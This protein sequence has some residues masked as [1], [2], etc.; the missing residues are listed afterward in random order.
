MSNPQLDNGYIK[1]ANTIMSELA[2]IRIP[3]QARQVLD[4]ILRKTY[5]W[6]KKTDVI[7]LSQF[8]EGTGL[9]KSSICKSLNKLLEMNLI[10]KK[11]SAMSYFTQLGNDYGITYGFQ[12]KFELWSPL[13]KKTTLFK[14]T[15]HVVQKGNRTLPK[16]ETPPIKDTIT[17]DTI[18]KGAY[19]K[20]F[21][22]FAKKYP[23]KKSKAKAFES[24]NKLKKAKM[25]P[26]LSILIAAINDQIKEK[27]IKIITGKFCAEWK[28]PSTWLNQKCWEDEADINQKVPNKSE[29]KILKNAMVAEQIL[30]EE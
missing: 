2:K 14:K 18:T 19:S 10:T 23:L 17:K 24:W 27:E 20:N 3:G 21:I 15:K 28:H 26:E 5:G 6:N 29:Q 11:G 9:S 7:S 1:I 22:I 12:K 8:A 25:L 16:K 30:M 13:P 4:F